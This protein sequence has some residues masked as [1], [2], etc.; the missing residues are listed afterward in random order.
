MLGI[1]I[2]H[3]MHKTRLFG[4]SSLSYRLLFRLALTN[5]FLVWLGWRFQEMPKALIAALSNL[6]ITQASLIISGFAHG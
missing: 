1:A 2:N 3:W 4:G 5:N 6:S